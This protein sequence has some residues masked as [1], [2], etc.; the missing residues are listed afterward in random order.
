MPRRSETSAPVRAPRIE[1]PLCTVD[2]VVF[3]VHEE[4]L[5]VL[6][7]Q[8]PDAPDEPFPRR[9]AL[10]GGFVDP[11]ADGSLEACAQRKLAEKTSVVP[12]YLEQLGSWGDVTRDPRGWAATHVYFTLMPSEDVA[13][14]VG[15]NAG[16]AKWVPVD[17]PSRWP[18]LAFDHRRILETAVERLRSKVEYTS[19]PAYLLPEQFTLTE[20]QRRFEIVLGRA[21][22]KSAF[23]TRVLSV[24]WLEPLQAM[25]T[26]N[27]RPAQLY[28]L[29]APG[30]LMY[31]PRTFYAQR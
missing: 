12:P 28:R 26:G 19:L 5:C 3:T 1:R 6:L 30:E 24:D 20:L 4:Q 7:V 9:W 18:S 16:E 14:K 10:P 27:F 8:R 23:R 2:V 21:I 31:F 13:L 17:P 11:N 15:G 25:R 22:E 29:K